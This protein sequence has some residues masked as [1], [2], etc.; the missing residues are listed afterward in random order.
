M[1]RAMGTFFHDH[2][3]MLLILVFTL[4][5]VFGLMWLFI[6]LYNGPLTS[7]VKQKQKEA[8]EAEQTKNQLSNL[9]K[10]LEA[11]NAQM[12]KLKTEV[13][14]GFHNIDIRITRMEGVLNCKDK[15]TDH[16]KEKVTND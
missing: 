11:T 4:L 6:R 10:T 8:V 12:S 9:T 5:L 16:E 15:E 7:F 3:D 13:S 2:P 1:V 14:N